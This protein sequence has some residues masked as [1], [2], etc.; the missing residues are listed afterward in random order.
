V[1]RLVESIYGTQYH[2]LDPDLP[3][4]WCGL[5][6]DRTRAPV[7]ASTWDE[8][9]ERFRCQRCYHL[10]P[11]LWPFFRIHRRFR[12]EAT[13]GAPSWRARRVR[14]ARKRDAAAR[15]WSSA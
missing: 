4:T 1:G 3:L 6:P 14:V 2:T 5:T 7:G 15:R 8:V 10:D 12:V 11:S 13:G 9:P